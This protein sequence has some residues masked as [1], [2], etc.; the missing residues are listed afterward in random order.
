MVMA[1]FDAGMMVNLFPIR[2][3]QKIGQ[4]AAFKMAAFDQNMTRAHR[5]KRRPRAAH[6]GKI[7]RRDAGQNFGL[8]QI[9]GH[10]KGARNKPL[11]Q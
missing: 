4:V 3:H 5:Q 1:R 10:Q 6:P 11:C 2:P 7:V 8:D 9:G